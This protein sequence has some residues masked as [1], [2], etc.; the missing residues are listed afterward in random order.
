M[1][2]SE[3]Q[4]ATSTATWQLDPTASS[5]TFEHKAMWGLAT[6]RGTFS[7]LSG[8]GEIHPDGS[9]S[10]RLVIDAASLDTRHG[11]RDKH[12]RSADFFNSDAHPQIVADISAVTRQGGATAAV[13]GTLTVAGVTRPVTFTAAIAEETGDAVTLKAET[14][15]DRADFGMSWNQLGTIKGNATISVVA[16]FTRPADK[17]KG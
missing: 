7:G 1:T 12:L 14:H 8:S 4:R 13:T 16:R 2:T 6:V 3:G 5:V 10:G 9:A 11:K 15:I 17:Q